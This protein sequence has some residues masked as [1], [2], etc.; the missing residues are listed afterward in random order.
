MC[1]YSMI[2]VTIMTINKI[3]NKIFSFRRIVESSRAL[4][5]FHGAKKKA[6]VCYKRGDIAYYVHRLK[7]HNA[8]CFWVSKII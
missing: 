3:S 8:L 1:T 6:D 5:W 7:K 2:I 4:T